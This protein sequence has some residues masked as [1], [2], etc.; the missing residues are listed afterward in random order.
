M[1]EMKTCRVGTARVPEAVLRR[2]AEIRLWY[3][4]DNTP[5]VRFHLLTDDPY[6]GGRRLAD[7]FRDA[8]FEEVLS[9]LKGNWPFL[10]ESD[11]YETCLQPYLGRWRGLWDIHIEQGRRWLRDEPHAAA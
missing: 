7:L 3:D 2:L 4:G 6:R 11:F 5:E 10:L 9:I 1:N 8:A